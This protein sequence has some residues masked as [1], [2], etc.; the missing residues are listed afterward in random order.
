MCGELGKVDEKRIFGEIALKS[1]SR[2][3]KILKNVLMT[4]LHVL[5]LKATI[6]MNLHSKI[7]L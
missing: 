7:K 3:N 1:S 6:Q 4:M 5:S 2:F